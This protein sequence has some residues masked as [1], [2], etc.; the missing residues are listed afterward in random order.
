M[1]NFTEQVMCTEPTAPTLP[2][3]TSLKKQGRSIER[4][5]KHSTTESTVFNME[6][7]KLE[8]QS[9]PQK[10][11]NQST[12][13]STRLTDQSRS[14]STTILINNYPQ[15]QNEN[16]KTQQDKTHQFIQGREDRNKI[17][18]QK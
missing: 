17:Y 10:L 3:K 16:L 8:S 11:P 2:N 5:R 12:R 9:Q 7:H 14:L 13:Q 4:N 15:N 6:L 18:Y 1:K